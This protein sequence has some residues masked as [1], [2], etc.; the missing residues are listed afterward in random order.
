MRHSLLGSLFSALSSQLKSFQRNKES[1]LVCVAWQEESM[2]GDQ[3]H[4]SVRFGRKN[5]PLPNTAWHHQHV[6]TWPWRF[7]SQS[8]RSRVQLTTTVVVL[9]VE[10]REGVAL[11]GA[12]WPSA[13]FSVAVDFYCRPF[14]SISTKAS[15]VTTVAAWLRCSNLLLLTRCDAPCGASNVVAPSFKSLVAFRASRQ[16]T[17]MTSFASRPA[18]IWIGSIM[19][20]QAPQ[21]NK[22]TV[23]PRIGAKESVTAVHNCVGKEDSQLRTK[24]SYRGNL[25]PTITICACCVI[26]RQSQTGVR[27]PFSPR[28]DAV[29]TNQCVQPNDL[30]HCRRK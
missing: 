4:L 3:F 8:L 26:C 30:G 9:E 25:Q 14:H 20:F 12:V 22:G 5:V 27:T 2:A 13:I 16:F 17:S 15:R 10:K 1:F 21:I 29:L 28:D 24:Y 19:N 11:T 23:A 18:N 7:G 6:S